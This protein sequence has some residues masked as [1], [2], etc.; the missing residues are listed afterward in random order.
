VM[1]IFRLIRLPRSPLYLSTRKKCDVA[2]KFLANVTVVQE[3]II[4]PSPPREECEK[5]EQTDVLAYFA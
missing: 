5:C 4:Q 1:A 3:Q 2:Y